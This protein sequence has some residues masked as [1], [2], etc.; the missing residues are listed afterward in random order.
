MLFFS[1][2]IAGPARPGRLPPSRALYSRGADAARGR[3]ARI[4]DFAVKPV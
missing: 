2:G 1:C 3:V 4:D